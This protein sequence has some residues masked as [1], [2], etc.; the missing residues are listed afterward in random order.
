MCQVLCFFVNHLS[1]AE[2]LWKVWFICG[3]HTPM[4]VIMF[5]NG[6][7]AEVKCFFFNIIKLQCPQSQTTKTNVCKLLIFRI[8]LIQNV[9]T[10][11]G[12]IDLKDVFML[13]LPPFIRKSDFI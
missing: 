7:K 4:G 12:Q 5:G 1:S 11:C 6:G 8:L 2:L 13:G 10:S 3:S 9:K